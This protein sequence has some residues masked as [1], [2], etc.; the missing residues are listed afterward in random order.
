MT[1][2]FKTLFA[3]SALTLSFVSPASAD[4]VETLRDE[5]N[6]EITNNLSRDL[7][8][9]WITE[10]DYDGRRETYASSNG[11]GEVNKGESYSTQISDS[12]EIIKDKYN[13]LLGIRNG[14]AE[15]AD[16]CDSVT[17]DCTEIAAKLK[18]A[19][20]ALQNVRETAEETFL[21]NDLESGYVWIT[22]DSDKL[23]RMQG[24]IDRTI[25][26]NKE[27]V[28]QKEEIDKVISVLGNGGN[29][30]K[31]SKY[32][33]VSANTKSKICTD[34]IMIAADESAKKAAEVYGEM[35]LP[36]KFP[37]KQE[38]ID[39]LY[40]LVDKTYKEEL[41]YS[42]AISTYNLNRIAGDTDKI[43]ADLS[44]QALES[45]G[46]ESE[47][48]SFNSNVVA[49]IGSEII[50]LIVNVAT[51]TTLEAIGAVRDIPRKDVD[52]E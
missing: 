39:L 32:P 20:D 7:S 14:Y 40:E 10:F 12:M 23:V 9:K 49:T 22:K 44:T 51:T 16:A 8:G 2:R 13:Q 41:V 21:N 27:I 52:I 25:E 48:I 28:E 43:I 50:P 15:E 30:A 4:Y 19:N 33:S 5:I 42:L 35:L 24:I 3:I 38:D 47:A 1:V 29:S 36:T 31:F 6:A 45:A 34:S 17:E 26:K 11:E 18:N 46:T 37:T